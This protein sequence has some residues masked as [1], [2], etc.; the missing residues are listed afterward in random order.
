MPPVGIELTMPTI[1]GL[2]FYCLIYS[3]NLSFLASLKFL[4]PYKVMLY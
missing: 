3:A 2:E 4:D 1:C